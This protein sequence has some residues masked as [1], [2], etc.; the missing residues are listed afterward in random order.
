MKDIKLL[1]LSA[2][3]QKMNTTPYRWKLV[4]NTFASK[5][6]AKNLLDTF[7]KEGFKR[8]Q[9]DTGSK[10]HY[11]YGRCLIDNYVENAS[12]HKVDSLSNI[13]NDL[14][15]ELLSDTYRKLMSKTSEISLDGL[16]IE[17]TCWRHLYGCFIDPHPDKPEKVLTHLFYF[18]QEDWK[19]T[20]GGCLRIL[21]NSDIENYTDEI[22]PLINTS[23]FFVRSDNSW[24]GTKPISI[25]NRARLA[26]QV[27]F[28]KENMHYTTGYK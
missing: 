12:V 9:R 14:I 6:Y 15:H 28:H 20:D 8:F 19:S 10:R 3:C 4:K 7:P 11:F 13:W 22:L 1:N 21:R 23:V 26:L 27:V 24:H 25:P 16:R 2:I 18:N 5:E 17:I